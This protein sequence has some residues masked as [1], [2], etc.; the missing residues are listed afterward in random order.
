MTDE[1][2]DKGKTM[3]R[4]HALILKIVRYVRKKADEADD[5]WVPAPDFKPEYSQSSVDYHLTLCVQA[6]Y[7]DWRGP[8]GTNRTPMWSVTWLGHDLLESNNDC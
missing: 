5:P 1:M 2:Q 6:G 8:K 7:L 3:T 4:N